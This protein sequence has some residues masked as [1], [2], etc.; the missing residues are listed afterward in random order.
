MPAQLWWY[1]FLPPYTS[2][3][4]RKSLKCSHTNLDNARSHNARRSTECPHAK[5]IERAQHPAS[6]PDLAPKDFFLFGDIKSKLT[7]YDIPDR[8]S[9]QSVITHIFDEIGQETLITVFETWINRLK[10]VIEHEVEY[11]H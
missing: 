2:H 6:S 9:L 3:S 1:Y 10:W 11:L 7:E 8:Q 4:R 5:R